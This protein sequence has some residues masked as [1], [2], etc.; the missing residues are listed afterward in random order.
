MGLTP[1][2]D[3]FNIKTDTLIQLLED[4]HK[5]VDDILVEARSKTQLVSKLLT[6]FNACRENGVTLNPKS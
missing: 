3:Y 4:V 1:S 2:G 6:L 5:S